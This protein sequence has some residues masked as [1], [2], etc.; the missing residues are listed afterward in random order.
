[1]DAAELKKLRLPVDFEVRGEYHYA[2]E[3]VSSL[4][5]K[6]GRTGRETILD[7]RSAA[8]G[9]V[10]VARS[11]DYAGRGGSIS[12]RIFSWPTG[13][14]PHV[15]IQKRLNQCANFTQGFRPNWRLCHSLDEV[16]E[17]YDIVGREAREAAL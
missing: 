1:V 14:S 7:P 17:V 10:R 13:A 8:A 12:M 2:P 6:A 9:S 3:R 5:R 15:C 4:E 11:G 16:K